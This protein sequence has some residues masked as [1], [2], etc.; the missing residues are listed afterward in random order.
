MDVAAEVP[1]VSGTVL[2]FRRSD[3][4]FH[5]HKPYAGERKVVQM[6]WVTERK[7][8]DRNIARQAEFIRKGARFI[9]TNSDIAFMMAE[10]SRV[11]GELRKALEQGR[12]ELDS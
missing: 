12:S 7:F 6:N 1:P 8:A 3:R 4:S 2:I 5:G 10:A 11:T 9:T